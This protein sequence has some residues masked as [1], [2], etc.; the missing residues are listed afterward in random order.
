MLVYFRLVREVALGV[1]AELRCAPKRW[2]VDALEALQTAAEFH[3]IEVLEKGNLAAIHAK[4]VTIKRED[5][6]LV[7][8][9]MQK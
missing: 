5:I 4:R 2:R 9:I 3:L 6:R 8:R 7:Q 1:T